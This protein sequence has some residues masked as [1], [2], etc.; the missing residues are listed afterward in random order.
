MCQNRQRKKQIAWGRE[1]SF[2][3]PLSK[4]LLMP[5]TFQAFL[6]SSN[7]PCNNHSIDWKS[8]SSE[9]CSID[10]LPA[11]FPSTYVDV[12]EIPLVRRKY[13]L[14]PRNPCFSLTLKS[15]LFWGGYKL[16]WLGIR[17]GLKLKARTKILQSEW[18]D[19]KTFLMR[20]ACFEYIISL[21]ICKNKQ[22]R[23]MY[24]KKGV[25]FLACHFNAGWHIGCLLELTKIFN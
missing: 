16:N 23:R 19:E 8:I 2:V 11:K 21:F 1:N 4:C 24:A 6:P 22:P 3:C 14:Q 5:K 17:A 25:S 18:I 7:C 9:E 13:N 20:D 12:V 15:H 10:P